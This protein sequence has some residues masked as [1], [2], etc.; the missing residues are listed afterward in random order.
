MLDQRYAEFLQVAW[1]S[2]MRFSIRSVRVQQAFCQ[3]YGMTT[4]IL[5]QHV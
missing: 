2:R 1:L 3:A 4:P 5:G